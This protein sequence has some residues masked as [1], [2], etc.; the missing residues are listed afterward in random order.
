VGRLLAGSRRVPV[1][2]TIA[3]PPKSFERPGRLL[4]G[5]AIVAQSRWTLERMQRAL[6][7]E[8]RAR[9]ARAR[10][11][12]IP[13]PLSAPASRSSA[14]LAAARSELGIAPETP[15]LTYPGDLET[16]GGAR[17]VAELVAPLS[18]AIEDLVVVFA[19]RAKSPRA[20][21][22]ARSLA[23]TL[24]PRRVRIKGDV[25]DVLALIQTSSAVL[26]PVDD[27]W[28]KVDLPIVLLEAMSLGVPIVT[29]DW[30]P[31]A[32]LGGALHVPTGDHQALLSATLAVLAEE[33]LRARIVSEQRAAVARRHDASVVA[34]AY[35]QL[36]LELLAEPA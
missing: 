5:D 17:A 31:L 4:F 3:S 21:E 15:I 36:Y 8:P 2:Q 7:Q 9:A 19:Y 6:E 29:Y 14:A 28:G 10:L 18:R 1:L 13:P 30:G 20:S 24:D 32:E 22:V 34:R 27:L 33:S 23:R 12:L 11:E 16:S 35:E 25:G 26:F